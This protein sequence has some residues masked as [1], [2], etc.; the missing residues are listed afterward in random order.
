MSNYYFASIPNADS[1]TKKKVTS[2]ERQP[3][4]STVNSDSKKSKVPSIQRQIKK[5][6]KLNRRFNQVTFFK[7]TLGNLDFSKDRYITSPSDEFT[8][9]AS[10][11]KT[12]NNLLF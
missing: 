3:K 7:L 12:I 5:V 8:F 9:E 10:E 11:T 1:A 2:P 6:T 4:E